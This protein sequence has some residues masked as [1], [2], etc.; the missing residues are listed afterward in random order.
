VYLV[1]DEGDQGG[2][3]VHTMFN[4]SW[5]RSEGWLT[6]EVVAGVSYG[7]LAEPADKLCPRLRKEFVFM[8]DQRRPYQEDLFC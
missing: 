4:C 1:L 8:R 6:S 2:D 5:G 3:I 7:S